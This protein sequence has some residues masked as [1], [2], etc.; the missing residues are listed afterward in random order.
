MASTD[1]SAGLLFEG[2]QQ[3]GLARVAVAHRR[4]DRAVARKALHQPQV[5]RTS[6]ERSAGRVPQRV[7]AEM[8]LKAG[9]LLPNGEEVPDLPGRQ[10]SASAADEKWCIGRRALVVRDFPL[11]ELRQLEAERLREDGFL[12][13]R[14]LGGPLE[15]FQLNAAGDAVVARLHIRNVQRDDFV[16]P[17]TSA[18]REGEQ[19]VVA[20]CTAAFSGGGEECCLFLFGEH[21]R[22]QGDRLEVKA[23]GDA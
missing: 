2:V 21:R 12:D 19:H 16:L 11:E 3:L 23:H 22:R 14:A 9:A 6:V 13:S 4:H 15:H 10:P 1:V 8:T 18:E 20:E 5:L 17:K 7:K